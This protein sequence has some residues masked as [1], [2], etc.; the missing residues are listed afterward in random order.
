MGG[1]IRTSGEAPRL[2]VAAVSAV[3]VGGGRRQR[4]GLALWGGGGRGSYRTSR[5]VP[6]IVQKPLKSYLVFEE[7][8]AWFVVRFLVR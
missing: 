8:F 6:Q 7:V 4:G 5:I 2:A 3:T 1:G